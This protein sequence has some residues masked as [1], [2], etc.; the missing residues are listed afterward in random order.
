MSN[1]VLV[2]GGQKSGSIWDEVSALLRQKGHVVYT[3]SLSPPAESSLSGHISEICDL[4]ESKRLGAITLAGHSYGSMVI[5]GVANLHSDKMK[6]LVYIDCVV[7]ET[8]KS[9]YGMMESLGIS[10]EEYDLPQQPPF[11]EPLFFDEEIIR[12]I[13]K[14]Y[15]HCAESEFIEVGKP[16]FE[17]V[18]EV[19][20][21]DNWDY[22]TIDSD[23]SC[24]ISHPQ[25]LAA[26]L[27]RQ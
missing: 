17:R 3:P 16:C 9:L 18:V 5:T 26:I 12:G 21:R 13:P 15:V 20:N 24:M 6:R 27:L 25:E 22:F 8:G 7:P 10:S 23:H 14:T 4:I 11:L 1:Y 19:A 2:H